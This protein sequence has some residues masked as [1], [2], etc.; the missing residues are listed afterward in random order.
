MPFFQVEIKKTI[1]V[2][3][4]A[5]DESD[6]YEYASSTADFIGDWETEGNTQ[7]AESLQEALELASM[8]E[9]TLDDEGDKVKYDVEQ[10]VRDHWD[11]QGA[12]P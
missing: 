8:G 3:L 2:N 4:F 1:I 12:T 11:E 5:K 9:L 10:F 7:K 6:A